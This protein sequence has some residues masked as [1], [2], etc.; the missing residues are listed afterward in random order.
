MV[1][2]LV[3]APRPVRF[4]RGQARGHAVIQLAALEGAGAGGGVVVG[5]HALQLRRVEPERRGQFADA[6]GLQRREHAGQV[7]VQR[8]AVADGEG[9]LI[10]LLRDQPAPDRVTLGPDILA[11]VVEA[12]DILVHDDGIGHAIE[13]HRQAAIAHRRPRVVGDGVELGRVADLLDPLSQQILQH[14]A[15]GVGGAADLEVVGRVAPVLPQPFPVGLEAAG[16]C[17]DRFAADALGE[18]A[19]GDHRLTREAVLHQDFSHFGVVQDLDAKLFGGAVH[20]VHQRLAAA[21]EE[22][23]GA[24]QAQRARQAGLEHHAAVAQEAGRMGTGANRHARQALIGA[25][26]GDAQQVVPVFLLAIAFGQHLGRC[27][28]QRA[29]VAGMPRIATAHGDRRVLGNDDRG[30]GLRRRDSGRQRGIA[31]PNHQDVPYSCEIRHSPSLSVRRRAC[32]ER[33]PLNLIVR[34]K[35]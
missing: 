14:R 8:L 16:R 25:A 31:A 20:G 30:T 10:G 5:H 33:Q 17:D 29:Q 13:P 1:G 19:P 22:G 34:S 6:G 11:L 27:R 35:P 28:V 4:R 23:V 32:P 24:A 15:L 18:A 3:D 9:P 12:F 7:I 21:Q 26:A 2:W